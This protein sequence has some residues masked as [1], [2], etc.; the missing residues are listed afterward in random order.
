[1]SYRLVR[2]RDPAFLTFLPTCLKPRYYGAE[3]MSDDAKDEAEEENWILARSFKL[4]LHPA[5]LRTSHNIATEG[6]ASSNITFQCRTLRLVCVGTTN[7][8]ALPQGVTVETIY[9]DLLRYLL[10][11]TRAFFETRTPKGATVWQQLINDAEFVI[12]HPNAWGLKEQ[13]L[14]RRAAIRAGCVSIAQSNSHV[15][16]VSEG[17]ASVH[18]SIAHDNLAAKLKV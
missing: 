17:E 4:H 5:E 14:L 15:R 13:H 16:F 8:T 6:E 18:Y 3:A 1:M 9:S 11:N 12:A 2:A 7:P 10:E